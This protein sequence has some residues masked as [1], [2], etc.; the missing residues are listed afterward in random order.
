MEIRTTNTLGVI[1]IS[2]QPFFDKRGYFVEAYNKRR[3]SEI[4]IN[5][6]FVQD[7]H[8]RSRQLTLRGLHYQIKHPQGKLVR[9]IVGEIFDVCVDLR[10][11]SPT[12]GKWE[13]FLL[14]EDNR[15]QVWIPPGFAHGFFALSK[16][17]EVIY[18]TT[19]YYMKE[20][21]RTI[22]WNDPDIGIKWPLNKKRIPII[23][24]KDAKGKRY[25]DAEVFD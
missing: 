24:D 10:K 9:A 2:P 18:K 14:S 11:S 21:D 4:G 3:F 16:W 12:F 25:K 8:S 13:G 7:N 23:S 19:E 20:F 1:L 15:F 6:D 22:L 5:Y 17:A